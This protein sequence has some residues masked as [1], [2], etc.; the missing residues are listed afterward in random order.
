MEATKQS[1]TTS[2]ELYQ[3][4]ARQPFGESHETLPDTLPED[5]EQAFLDLVRARQEVAA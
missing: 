3:F 2:S 5:L 1:F 4:W